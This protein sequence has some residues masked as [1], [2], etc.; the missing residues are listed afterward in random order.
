MTTIKEKSPGTRKT[1]SLEKTVN[2]PVSEVWKA[3]TNCELLHK[4]WGPKA[5]TCPHCEINLQIGGKYFISMKAK[6]GE[7]I[8][9]T[10]IYK[11]IVPYKKLVMTDSFSDSSG[12]IISAPAE[13]AGDW[14]EALLTTV[15]LQ[16]DNEKTF[17][18]LKQEGLPVEA[19]NDCVQGWLESL[20]KLENNLKW[21]SI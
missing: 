5:Y 4:W 13:M 11:E 20:D 18:S 21:H 6:D 3:W 1:L 16:A 2:L 9:S 17:I 7:E 8:Y 14:P 15:E 19:Y 10:G 12:N